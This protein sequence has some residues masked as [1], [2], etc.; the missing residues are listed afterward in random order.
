MTFF[1]HH[2][3]P[4]EWATEKKCQIWLYDKKMISGL[5]DRLYSSIN[6]SIFGDIQYQRTPFVDED[7]SVIFQ[8]QL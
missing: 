3:W 7:S 6:C 2:N 5:K 1:T 8:G 4:M